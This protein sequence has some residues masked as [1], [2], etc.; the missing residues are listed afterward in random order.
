M[1]RLRALSLVL[2]LGLAAGACGGGTDRLSKD[3]Y[4]KKADEICK[5]MSTKSDALDAPQS[6]AD[7][8]KYVGEVAKIAHTMLSDLRALNGPKS[9]EA[10]V[11]DVYDT[12][13]K[14]LD[15]IVKDPSSLMTMTDNPFAD[16]GKKAKAYGFK[17]CGSESSA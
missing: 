12:Y 9:D 8:G 10:T 1:R 7:L 14:A 5:A 16:A 4:I 13:E 2:S 3:E 6:E 15:K 17:E 11:A